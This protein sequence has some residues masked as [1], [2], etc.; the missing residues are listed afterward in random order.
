MQGEVRQ[1][2]GRVEGRRGKTVQGEVRCGDDI[3][4]TRIASQDR[5]LHYRKESKGKEGRNEV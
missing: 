2:S 1:G 4:Y 5:V 3:D